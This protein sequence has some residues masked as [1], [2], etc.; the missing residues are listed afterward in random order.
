MLHSSLVA[1]L[2]VKKLKEIKLKMH[3]NES[4][5]VVRI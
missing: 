1:S 3:K 4:D 5:D 2:M